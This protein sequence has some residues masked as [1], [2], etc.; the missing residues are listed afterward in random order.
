MR[1]FLLVLLIPLIAACAS[2]PDNS[3]TITGNI[4]KNLSLD[5]CYVYITPSTIDLKETV[6]DSC[7]VKDGAFSLNGKALKNSELVLLVIT[8]SIRKIDKNTI[9]TIFAFESGNIFFNVIDSSNIDV[10]GSPSNDMIQNCIIALA[11]YDSVCASLV[12][13]NLPAAESYKKMKQA[14]KKRNEVVK[15]NILLDPNS[16]VSSFIFTEQHFMFN[17]DELTEF[18]N[19]LVSED[20]TVVKTRMQLESSRKVAE[21]QKINNSKLV[22]ENRDTLLLYDFLPGHEYLLLDF[23][24]SWCGP[25]IRKT[26]ELKKLYEDYPR[27]KFDIIGISLDTDE[28][29]WV[30]AIDKIDLSWPNF[31]S[32][33]GWECP[34]VKEYAINY[35]PN[36]LLVDSNGVVVCRNPTIDELKIH[37]NK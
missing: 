32:L 27:E 19:T 28:A 6:I 11:E 36:T 34:L 17:V 29:K 26:L 3:Y 13:S 9:G 5:G 16:A 8:D 22:N 1:N 14:A 25:C 10:S 2:K 37:F 31:S 23:W 30:K 18:I 4:N 21:G 33:K 15:K 35:I 7:I 24:A 20:E 12:N